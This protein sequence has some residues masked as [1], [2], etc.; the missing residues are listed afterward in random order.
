MHLLILLIL[1]VTDMKLRGATNSPKSN[2]NI[3]LDNEI[4][5]KILK[6]AKSCNYIN[7]NK[8]RLYKIQPEK[9]I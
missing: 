5:L 8:Y 9:T 7:K 2:K 3:M 4:V 6:I 1:Q